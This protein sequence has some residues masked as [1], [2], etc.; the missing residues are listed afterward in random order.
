M[1][2][3]AL[4]IPPPLAAASAREL[5]ILW[6]DEPGCELAQRLPMR[7]AKLPGDKRGAPAPMGKC[8][9]AGM[10][11]KSSLEV[12]KEEAGAGG[13]QH[14]YKT[15]LRSPGSKSA[16]WLLRHDQPTPSEQPGSSSLSL[17]QTDT[18]AFLSHCPGFSSM[19]ATSLQHV[20]LGQSFTAMQHCNTLRDGFLKAPGAYSHWFSSTVW[21][22]VNSQV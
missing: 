18:S 7:W 17:R 22:S 5:L 13:L 6:Q 12:H 10:C 3:G 19:F 9:Q 2:K 4:P 21:I 15:P 1:V 8:H 16:P 11:R 14:S 20:W